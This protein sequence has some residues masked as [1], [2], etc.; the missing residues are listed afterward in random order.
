MR[1]KL[2]ILSFSLIFTIA[3]AKQTLKGGGSKEDDQ[4]IHGIIKDHH[5]DM[6]ECSTQYFRR[7]NETSGV[8][9]AKFMIYPKGQVIGIH[10]DP[11][12][13]AEL[14]ECL[15]SIIKLMEFPKIERKTKIEVKIPLK[16]EKS[17]D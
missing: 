6:I 14:G 15:E 17:A 3:C 2:I 4:I 7:G 9:M 8:T 10:F 16:I 5:E 13:E 1:M 11:L 12:F